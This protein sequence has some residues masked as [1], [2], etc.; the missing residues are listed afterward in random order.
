MKYILTLLLFVTP[1]FA[2][3]PHHVDST[4]D[5]V[6]TTTVQTTQVLNLNSES[7][8]AAAMASGL[9]QFDS[10]TD[11]FQL[12]FS[13]ATY[14]GDAAG[15][16]GLAMRLNK[17]LLLSGAINIEEGGTVSGGGAVGIQF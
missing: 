17:K 8:V 15:S 16:V 6:N 1:L 2:A 10:S 9:H 12:S 11:D 14:E 13:A 5:T 3:D 7:A 4:T